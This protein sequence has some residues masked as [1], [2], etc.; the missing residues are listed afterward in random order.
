M[1]TP[2][3]SWADLAAYPTKRFILSNI[4]WLLMGII[5]A[6]SGP[7]LSPLVEMPLRWSK[8]S[9]GG[10]LRAAGISGRAVFP[11]PATVHER[12]YDEDLPPAHGLSHCR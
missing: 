5:H 12:L 10:L 8:A 3:L 6:L 4:C 9:C 1:A 7:R 2:I 11:L